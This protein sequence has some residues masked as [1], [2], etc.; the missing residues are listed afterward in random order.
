MSSSVRRASAASLLILSLGLGATIQASTASAAPAPASSP[1]AAQVGAGWIGRQFSAGGYI[2]TGGVADP[3]STVQAVLAFAASGVGGRKAKAAITWLK[4]HFE[5]YVSPGGVDEPGALAYVIL[6][7][8]AMGDYPTA[9]GGTKTANDLVRRLLDTQRTTGPD[10]GLFGSEDPTYDGA[11]RQGLSLMALANQGTSN[12]A[13]VT[14]LQN[15]QCSDGGWEAYR[16]DLGTPCPPPD[17]DAFAGPDTNSTALAVEGLVAQKAVDAP[18]NADITA[19]FE[20]AQNADGG[21]G[22]IGGSSQSPDPDSTGEVIQALVA[23]GQLDNAE[24]TQTGGTPATA[25]ATFQLG[26][27][28]KADQRGAYVFPGEKGPN[29]VATLQAVPGAAEVA[30]PLKAQTLQPGLP[31][32]TCPAV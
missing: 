24:F 7:A 29:M 11:F 8:Q 27:S 17:P 32:L 12:P 28:A 23:L 1:G 10:A 4:K 15:Q 14:W 21:F 9:F 6:A 13:G 18:E 19:F 3:S 26:C 25:L 22:L 30:F 2:I 31:K 16:S 5:S 20:S